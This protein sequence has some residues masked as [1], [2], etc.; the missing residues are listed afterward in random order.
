[1]SSAA[2]KIEQLRDYPHEVSKDFRDQLERA[3]TARERMDGQAVPEASIGRMH[4][5]H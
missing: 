5:R 3:R 2:E 4:S 1:M